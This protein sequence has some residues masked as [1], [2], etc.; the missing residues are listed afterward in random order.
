MS[1][2]FD[3]VLFDAGGIFVVPDPIS[4]AMA[5][6]PFGGATDTGVLVR[7]HYAGMEALDAV[8][9]KRSDASIDKITWDT[10]RIA[11]LNTAGVAPEHLPAAT[12]AMRRL[13]SP[14][15]WCF[16]LLESVAALG[17]LYHRK[18]PIGV[19]SNASGQIEATLNNLCLCQV[20]PGAGVP[21]SIVTDSQV[22]GY[23]KPDPL[24]FGDAI[25][26]LNLAPERVAYVGDSYVNDVGGAR[27]AGL[28]PLLYDPFDDHADYDC[29]RIRSLHE[30]LEFVK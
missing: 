5:I 2:R 8:A 16:P 6:A 19:V 20:G 11:Y 24:I 4:T 30:L 13:F 22:V 18:V 10:Y 7:C 29:E 1:K 27:A 28:V 14:Q 21:V 9:S 25:A 23:A 3:G 26:A 15:Y 12:S 17:Q